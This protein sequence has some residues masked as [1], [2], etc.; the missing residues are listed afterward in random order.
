MFQNHFLKIVAQEEIELGVQNGPKWMIED[1]SILGIL[2]FVPSYFSR[3]FIE[4]F[5]IIFLKFCSCN[6]EPI[7]RK[8]VLEI[9]QNI[10]I[11]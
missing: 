5:E 10:F 11:P 6:N 9:N 8:M 7:T 2:A 1:L 3:K 4:E